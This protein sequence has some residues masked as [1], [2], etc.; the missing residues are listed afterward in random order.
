MYIDI[1]GWLATILVLL[2]F[3][4]NARKNILCFL[5]WIVG[6]VLWLYYSYLTDTI[7]HAGQSFVII[8][9]NIYGWINWV[10]RK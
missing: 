9:L 6:D 3:Y 1:I 10:S 4:F 7:P 2:G 8:V 5:S